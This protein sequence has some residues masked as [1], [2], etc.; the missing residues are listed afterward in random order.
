MSAASKNKRVP[1]RSSPRNNPSN[2]N[3]SLPETAPNPVTYVDGE[4]E[5]TDPITGSVPTEKA[6]RQKV[7]ASATDSITSAS[8]SITAQHMDVDASQATPISNT[9]VEQALKEAEKEFTKKAMLDAA[10]DALK[11]TNNASLHAPENIIVTPPAP[12]TTSDSIH[13]PPSE[14]GKEPAV[15]ISQNAHASES[16]PNQ[17]IK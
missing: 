15:T 14:K 3:K 7:A 13:A 10:K 6:K 1:T 5:T 2:G 17:A 9:L 11:P 8:T 4:K 12:Q 16:S